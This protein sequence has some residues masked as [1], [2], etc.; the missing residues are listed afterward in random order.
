MKKNIW[1]EVLPG[2]SFFKGPLHSPK[3]QD[4]VPHH[5]LAIGSGEIAF[6]RSM[7]VFGVAYD[8]RVQGWFCRQ[9]ASFQSDDARDREKRRERGSTVGRI[10]AGKSWTHVAS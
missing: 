4:E 8:R 7:Q 10:L 3:Y 1:T 6:L 9:P 5:S 2:R